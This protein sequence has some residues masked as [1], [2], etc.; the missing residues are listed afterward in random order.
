MIVSPPDPG[1]HTLRVINTLTS[2]QFSASS[3]W[4]HPPVKN[5]GF[6]NCCGLFG[7]SAGHHAS[8]GEKGSLCRL[9]EPSFMSLSALVVTSSVASQRL[10]LNAF[11]IFTKCF[12]RITAA[13]AVG[14]SIKCRGGSEKLLCLTQVWPWEGMWKMDFEMKGGG[15]VPYLPL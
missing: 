1:H 8:K 4:W 13:D 7:G 2:L 11:T 5:R 6:A 10:S 3:L 9:Q 15:K 12:E 14:S